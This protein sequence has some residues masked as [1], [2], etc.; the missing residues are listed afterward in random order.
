M[1]FIIAKKIGMTRR[2]RDDGTVVPVTILQAGPCT[3][4][5]V[6]TPDKDGYTAIQLGFGTK[7]H[8]AKPQQQAWTDMGSFAVVHEFRLPSTEGFARGKKLD[9]G[10][11]QPGAAVK[12]TGVSKGRGFQGV[13]KRHHFAGGPASHGHKDNLRAPGSIG[14]TFP[15]HVMKGTRMAGR[16]GAERVSVNQLEVIEVV[17]D[18]HLLLIKGA[19]PGPRN[20][21]VFVQSA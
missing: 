2:F 10:V 13:V 4:T 14:A 11:F 8:P 16:M 5:H 18:Q 21:I 12:V 17:P 7:R 19:V 1:S 20:G 3:V 6:R 9:V 15:Q